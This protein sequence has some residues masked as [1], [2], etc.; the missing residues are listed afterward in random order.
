MVT[1]TTQSSRNGMRLRKPPVRSKPALL[2]AEM[3]WNTQYS[4]TS[5]AYVRLGAQ[6]TKP[7]NGSSDSNLIAGAGGWHDPAPETGP[8]RCPP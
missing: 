7:D 1:S 2:N 6:Q 3:E 5:R 4:E 8:S